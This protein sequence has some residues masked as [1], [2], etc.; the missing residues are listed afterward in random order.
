MSRFVFVTGLLFGALGLMAQEIN[1]KVEV[2][3]DSLLYGNYFEVRFTIENAA[4]DF[5]APDFD[6]FE[7]LSGPNTSSSFSMINGKVTQKASYAYVLRPVR[8]G[9]LYIHPAVFR[10]GG[11]VLETEP[12]LIQV[13]PNPAGIEEN[14]TFR[15]EELDPFFSFP[16]REEPKKKNKFKDK[17]RRI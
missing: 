3:S 5:E 7:V 8:E 9:I 13:H 10:T 2:S 12:L 6:G 1:L 14:K 17:V 11:E 4:G 15:D 16:G